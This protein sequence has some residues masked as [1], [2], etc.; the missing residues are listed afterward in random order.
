MRRKKKIDPQP[1]D[2]GRIRQPN[3]PA[4]IH[5]P[6]KKMELTAG[7]GLGL[8]L[9]TAY[10]ATMLRGVDAGDSA[11]LQF[12]SPLLGVCHPPGY[13]VEVC[14]GK[15]FSMLPVGPSIAWRIN[16]MMVIS[17]IAGCLAL[18]GTIRRITGSI[19]AGIVG[20]LTLGFSSIYWSFSLAAEVYV[21]Y[22]MFLLLGIY[23]IARFIDSKHPVWLYAAA[24]ALG[25]CTADRISE[26]LIMP[27]FL[28]LWASVRKHVK[29]NILQFLAAMIVFV[30]PFVFTVSFHLIQNHPQK[31]FE[32]LY[33]RDSAL[34]FQI[35][36]DNFEVSIPPLPHRIKGAVQYCLGLMYKKDAKFDSSM[37]A[38]DINKYAWLLSGLGAAGERFPS[39]DRR[40]SEQGTGTSI[41]ILGLAAAAA[42]LILRRKNWGWLVLGLWMF[43]ANLIF[44][45]W[46]HRWDNLTFTVP[47]LAGLAMLAGIGAA[48]GEKAAG[49]T[50]IYRV[51]C[52]IIPLFLLITNYSLVN[53]NT[54]AEKKI[55]EQRQQISKASFAANSVIITTYWPAMTYR[56]LIQLEG[57]REDIRIIHED[58]RNWQKI[59]NYFL[60][61]GQFVYME[62]NR[63]NSEM[64]RQC[65]PLTEPDVWQAGFA[66]LP[67]LEQKKK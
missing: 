15:L 59:I 28:L 54:A 10:M 42:G 30:L 5:R 66:K 1:I 16:F 57:G 38:W 53:R 27:G 24:A 50:V 2:N 11:E 21:F 60:K 25:I 65:Q 33:G 22:A 31:R 58:T 17:G 51:I 7:I 9:F 55:L 3:L 37:A 32:T 35:L 34:R 4:D 12:M 40:N 39:G 56:Y 14:F 61:E 48:G 36:A 8:F 64:L 19:L 26:I 63:M 18:Y 29:I 23:C 44:I 67:L 13:A 6:W 46:H 41:G 45:L 62:R 43:S 49:K 52:L 47:G 20:A